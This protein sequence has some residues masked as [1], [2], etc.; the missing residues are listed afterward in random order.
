MRK[1]RSY[2]LLSLLVSSIGIQTTT[3]LASTLT[4]TE[5]PSLEQ[6]ET[7]EST[8]PSE[9]PQVPS[10]EPETPIDSGT[11]ESTTETSVE[12]TEPSKPVEEVETSTSESTDK[13]PTESKPEEKIPE[14]VE[15][16]E[17]SSVETI[18]YH[19]SEGNE[20]PSG[21]PFVVETNQRTQE[22]IQ[23]IGEDARKIGKDNDLYASVMIAQA[24]L[25]SASGQSELASEPN[26]NLFGIKGE[27]EGQSVSF[28]TSEDNGSGEL[29]SVQANFRKYPSYKESLK[30][31]ADLMKKGLEWDANF[32]HGVSKKEASSYQEATKFLT[33][34]YATDINYHNK[35][36]GLIESY[37]LTLFD[38]EIDNTEGFIKPFESEQPVTSNFGI[39]GEENHRGVDFSADIGTPIL[40]IQEGIVV[41]STLHYSWGEYVKVQHNNGF[42]SLYAHQSKRAVEVGQSVKKGQVIGYVGSTGNSTGPHA[43]VELEL[44][45]QL[46][47]LLDFIH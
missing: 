5:S 20:L 19:V 16:V 13:K 7:E 30:D 25:E 47:N 15:V 44:N 6:V 1:I 29:Y 39:R 2:F 26:F 18:P 45:N 24:I 35:L 8:L 42:T 17:E 34:K 41:E 23:K 46:V 31:Y 21:T 27:F 38:R 43:H 11:E 40:A 37:H 4:E 28:L 22:F 33:G 14:V 9:E 10:E 36:N 12:P 3:A 32:Y